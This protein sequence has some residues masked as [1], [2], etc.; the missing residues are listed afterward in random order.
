MN[1]GDHTDDE[2][3]EALLGR[4]DSFGLGFNGGIYS[5]ELNEKWSGVL[6]GSVCD[7]EDLWVEAQKE[8]DNV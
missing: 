7:L 8:L 2:L 1:I 4:A 6:M 5:D 3:L